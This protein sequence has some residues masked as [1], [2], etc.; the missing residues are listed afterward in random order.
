M[1]VM[2]DGCGLHTGNPSA[3][4]GLRGLRER[5]GQL[6]GAITLA[7]RPGGGTILAIQLPIQEH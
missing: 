1:Q 6:D 3:G 7:D 4:F 2:D 5:A